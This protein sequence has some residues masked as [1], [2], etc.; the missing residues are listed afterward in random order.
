MIEIYGSY[1]PLT[2]LTKVDSYL[3]NRDFTEVIH[4]KLGQ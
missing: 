2:K 3:E 1:V 4:L